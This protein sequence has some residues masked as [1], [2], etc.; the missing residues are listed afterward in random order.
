MI[1]VWVWSD[2]DRLPVRLRRITIMTIMM[3]R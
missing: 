3:S 2:R 1:I